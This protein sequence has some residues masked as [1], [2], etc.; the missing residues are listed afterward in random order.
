MS[1]RTPDETPLGRALERMAHQIKNPLQAVAMNLEVIRGRVGREAPETWEG[2][3]RFAEAV[4]ANVRLLDRRLRLLL[5]LGRRDPDEAPTEVDATALA[6]EF[7]AALRYDEEAPGVRVEGTTGIAARTRPGWLL[8]LLLE[9]WDAALEAGAEATTVRVGGDEDG[10]RIAVELPP[11]ARLEAGR[12]EGPAHRAG[13]T[14]EGVGEASD[15][16]SGTVVVLR[17]PTGGGSGG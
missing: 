15:E 14:L 1:G 2:V 11:D 10:V 4:D 8:A 12:L 13:A 3:E 9:L 7:A 16:R 17:L 6:R 5:A